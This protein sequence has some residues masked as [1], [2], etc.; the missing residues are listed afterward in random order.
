MK[1]PLQRIVCAAN[2]GMAFLNVALSADP[3]NQGWWRFVLSL[4]AGFN[5]FIF[6]MALTDNTWE[7]PEKE[8]RP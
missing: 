5:G 4:T 1:D 8:A 6:W 7:Q 2:L 3:G